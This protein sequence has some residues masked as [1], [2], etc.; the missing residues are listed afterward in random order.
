MP[1]SARSKINTLIALINRQ[2]L[3]AEYAPAEAVDDTVDADP[4]R[5]LQDLADLTPKY[6][7]IAA[8][9]IEDEVGQIRAR[10]T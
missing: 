5:G 4:D 1:R 2:V 10:C 3:A 6:G 8:E 9:P 7:F